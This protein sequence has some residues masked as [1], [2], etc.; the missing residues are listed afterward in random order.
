[1]SDQQ[2]SS[3]GIGPDRIDVHSS[4]SVSEWAKKL[5]V[6]DSQ[7]IDAVAAVGDLASEVELHLKGTRSTTNEERVDQAGGS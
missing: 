4:A 7:V 2:P 3:T 6:T 1:M 5:N